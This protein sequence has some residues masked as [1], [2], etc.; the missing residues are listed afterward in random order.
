MLKAAAA[1][2]LEYSEDGY[3]KAPINVV[4]I[5]LV[6]RAVEIINV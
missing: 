6:G 3:Y 5:W 2:H 1:E 4:E